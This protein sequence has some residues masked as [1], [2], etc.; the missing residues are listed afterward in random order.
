MPPRHRRLLRHCHSCRSCEGEPANNAASS[1]L[2]LSSSLWSCAIIVVACCR[3]WLSSC[4]VVSVAAI[5]SVAAD[6]ARESQRC[7]Q[8]TVIL[9]AAVI[10]VPHRRHQYHR[11]HARQE[12]KSQRPRAPPLLPLSPSCKSH[13]RHPSNREP[14]STRTAA[15]G[16]VAVMRA[17]KS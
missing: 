8:D 9:S 2:P 5:V 4:A 1:A 15:A 14:T 17:S 7:R 6:R 3:C 16:V 11:C 12:N 13:H 10:A